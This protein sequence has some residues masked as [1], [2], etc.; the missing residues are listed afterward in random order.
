VPV[1][2]ADAELQQATVPAQLRG[3]VVVTVGCL[4]GPVWPWQ[5]DVH[6]VSHHGRGIRWHGMPI[7]DATASV[8]HPCVP[9]PL[10]R[11]WLVRV[12]E[13]LGFLRWWLA[14]ANAIDRRGG[15]Q[16]WRGVP[17]PV[18]VQELQHAE[19]PGPLLSVV[20]DR[21][22]GVH[23]DVRRRRANADPQR[24]SSGHVRWQRVPR[25]VAAAILQHSAMPSQL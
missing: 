1:A 7:V 15:R 16:R 17:G 24:G 11:Q 9:G 10:R 25:F 5:P 12:V 3:V 4:L 14:D 22:V 21:V 23:P 13:M 6:A 8:Q 20:V 19:L 2:V 18:A